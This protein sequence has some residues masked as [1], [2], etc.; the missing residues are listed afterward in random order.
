MLKTLAK[1]VRE[2]KFVSLIT[3]VFMIIEVVM[4]AAI[5]LVCGKLINIINPSDGSVVSNE[6]LFDNILKYG[7]ILV[8]MA[9]VSLAGGI[10]GGI[11]GAKA[12]AGFA[13]NLRHDIFE[14]VEAFSFE[15][16]DSFQ[17]SSLV[18]RLTTDVGMVQM[19]YQMILRITI[20][21]PLQ[22]ISAII[23]A[24]SIDKE[25]PWIFVIIL[26][27]LGG[28][29]FAIARIVM[30]IFRRLFKK[31]DA[32]NNSVQENIRGIRVVKSYV[33]EDYEIE[34][35]DKVS[36]GLVKEFTIAERILAFNNPIMQVFIHTAIM[37][38]SYFGARACCTHESLFGGITDLEIGTLQSII[39]YGMQML[40]GLMILAMIFVMMSM[41]YECA[42]RIY[43][44]L[45]TESTL[46]NPEDPVYEVKDGSIEFTDVNFKYSE[47]ALKYAL[48]DIDL[49]IKSGQTVGIIGGT[50]SSKTTLV[51]LISRLYDV[52]SGSIKVGGVDVR[53]YDLKTL[54]DNVAVVLQKNVLFTG[55][56][57]ENLRWGNQDA[58]LEELVKAC[59]I[60]QALELVNNKPNKFDAMI[61]HGGANVSGGQKQ[62]LCIA[63]ALLKH[64]KVL[65]LDDSTSAVDTKT[66][67]LIRQGLKEYMPDATKIIIAQRVASIE[68]ADLIIVLDNGTINGVGTHDE[69]IKSNQI[70]QEV[71]AIQ[72]R[73]GGEANA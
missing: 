15:N 26:P 67:A 71:Y 33:R 48:F 9:L 3:P 5:I 52:S 60:S 27:L 20:R 16:I 40:S 19:A 17:T 55:T 51:N 47:K 69:L 68:N 31:Y 22:M 4:E 32:L 11:F 59:E 35:F 66:D 50:G 57:A 24:F 14:K 37:F 56:I 38:I 34:K 30:P 21:V 7:L 29:L 2:Y 49:K 8:G 64:P 42:N 41:S 39:T 1:S 46:T 63:R 53:D 28:A 45:N 23:L 58:S 62:R 18:T 36:Q 13:A 54:R 72:N 43:E 70:Y 6:V 61:E 25:L 44:V 73:V 12:S 65:I 10:G